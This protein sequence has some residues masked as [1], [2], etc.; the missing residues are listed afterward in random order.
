MGS[1]VDKENHSVV[2]IAFED[3]ESYAQWAGKS[4]PTEAQ[5]EYAARGGLSKMT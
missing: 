3:A 4:L 5:W 1:I 2:Q